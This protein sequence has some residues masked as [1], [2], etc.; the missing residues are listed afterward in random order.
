MTPVDF[1]IM[2]IVFAT[3]ALDGERKGLTVMILFFGLNSRYLDK[4]KFDFYASSSTGDLR[5]TNSLHQG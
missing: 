4:I 1:V 5:G 2:V 3:E